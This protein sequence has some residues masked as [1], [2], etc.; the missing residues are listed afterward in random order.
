M[1]EARW[2]YLSFESPLGRDEALFALQADPHER[3]D[4]A[5]DPDTANERARLAAWLAAERARVGDS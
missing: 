4:L 2:K 3:V 1:V 5:T